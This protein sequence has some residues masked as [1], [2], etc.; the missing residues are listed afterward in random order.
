[1]VCR[2]YIYGVLDTEY[3]VCSCC[4]GVPVCPAPAPYR[5]T[6][7]VSVLRIELLGI[8]SCEFLINPAYSSIQQE[9]GSRLCVVFTYL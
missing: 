9:S 1:M 8:V 3:E 6:W 7:G 4:Q 2:V 5:G